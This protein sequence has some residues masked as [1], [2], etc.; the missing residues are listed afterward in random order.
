MKKEKERSAGFVIVREDGNK[1][2][3]LGLLVWGKIDIPKG[4]VDPGES[5]LETAIRECYEE[6]SIEIVPSRDMRWGDVSY[7]AERKH[8]DVVVYV[9][10]TDQEAI[11]RPNP[12]TKQY[13]HDGVRWLSWD[14]MKERSYPYLRGAISWAQQIVENGE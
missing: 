9:A 8:K 5:D 1:W 7:V 11:I 6:S 3:V 4:H 12:K 14:D 2:E 13:E 10:S